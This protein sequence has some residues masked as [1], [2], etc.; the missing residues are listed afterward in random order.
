MFKVRSWRFSTLCA[1]SATLLNAQLLLAESPSKN[2]AKVFP[3]SIASGDPTQSGAVV[4]TRVNPKKFVTGATANLTVSRHHDLRNPTVI[5]SIDMSNAADRFYTVKFDLDGKLRAG[6]TY[7]YQFEYNGTYSRIGRFKTFPSKINSDHKARIAV[8]TCQDFSAGYYN[9]YHHLA[10]ED[11]DVMI[12]L[13][14]FFYD[15]GKY[16]NMNGLVRSIQL[17]SGYNQVSSLEDFLLVRETYLAD[18]N[19]QKALE[20]HAIIQIPDDHEYRDNVFYDYD[21]MTMGLPTSDPFRTRP[22]AF[23]EDLHLVAQKTWEAFT[24]SRVIIND[25]YKNSQEY[26]RLYRNFSYANLF[27]LYMIDSRTYRT[28]PPCQEESYFSRFTCDEAK[29]PNQT[30]LGVRQR[31]WLVRGLA[32]SKATWKILGNQTLMAELAM[33][34]AY[35]NFDAWDG[36]Q[37]EREVIMKSLREKQ[38]DNFVVFT[39]DMHTSMSTYLKSDYDDSDNDDPSNIIGAEFMTPSV[40]SPNVEDSIKRG[41]PIRFGLSMITSHAIKAANPHINHFNGSLYGY[42]I[43]EVSEKNLDWHVYNV[44]KFAEDA[45]TSSKT[46]HKTISYDPKQMKLSKRAP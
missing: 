20:K 21:R 4:W 43:A 33:G 39:G 25:Q 37:V 19:L 17:P 45:N 9:A 46:L 27:D 6:H 10:K 34:N 11:L 23:L 31:S 14:D 13:G 38:V 24:P 35:L 40:T 26:L 29:D 7:F 36:Y 15:Y 22:A 41:R 1:V 2:W 30:M 12:H 42:A 3:Q 18:R 5:E 28:E 44:D 32:S 8:L 16:P